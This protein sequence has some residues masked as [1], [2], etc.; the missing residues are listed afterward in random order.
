MSKTIHMVCGG[1]EPRIRDERIQQEIMDYEAKRL[2][3]ERYGD[4]DAPSPYMVGCFHQDIK[5]T[6]TG[7]LAHLTAIQ[8]K[9]GSDASDSYLAEICHILNDTF[10]KLARVERTTRG[11]ANFVP[12][13][14]RFGKEAQ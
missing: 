13:E 2:K 6:T 14:E 9:R 5:A 3:A 12:F 4:A 11:I 1:E 7:I 8:E 10:V